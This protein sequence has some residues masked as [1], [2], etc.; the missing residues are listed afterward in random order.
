M[1]LYKKML[2]LQIC[3]Q[4]HFSDAMLIG[5]MLT[6]LCRS[7]ALISDRQNFYNVMYLFK[8]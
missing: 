2:G 5:I 4:S 7:V 6:C 3:F 1:E 8:K